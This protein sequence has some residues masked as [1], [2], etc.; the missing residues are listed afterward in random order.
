MYSGGGGDVDADGGMGVLDHDAEV[1]AGRDGEFDGDDTTGTAL[2]M[3]SI[4]H[5]QRA[6]L[7]RHVT[8]PRKECVQQYR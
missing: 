3:A 4:A 7:A 6:L 5:Q 8:S 1:D 2:I